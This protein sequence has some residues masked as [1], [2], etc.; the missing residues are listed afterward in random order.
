MC[1]FVFSL[2]VNLRVRLVVTFILSICI[3]H[4]WCAHIMEYSHIFS[5]H[6]Y[7]D[8]Y[9]HIYLRKLECVTWLTSKKSHL[10]RAPMLKR[11]NSKIHYIFITKFEKHNI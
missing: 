9:T 11:K 3:K 6:L 8:L 10:G 4:S 7:E 2:S 5:M 1:I